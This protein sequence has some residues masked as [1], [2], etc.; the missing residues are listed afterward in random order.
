MPGRLLF[1]GVRAGLLTCIAAEY[2]VDGPGWAAAGKC[3]N[4]ESPTPD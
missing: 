3:N 4:H 1:Y 2:T